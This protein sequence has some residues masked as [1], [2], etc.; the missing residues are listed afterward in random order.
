MIVKSWVN[1]ETIEPFRFNR[2]D[3]GLLDQLYA[4]TFTPEIKKS[5]LFIERCIEYL[6]SVDIHD[7]GKQ[8]QTNQKMTKDVP[9][10]INIYEGYG[11]KKNRTGITAQILPTYCAIYDAAINLGAESYHRS[12]GHFQM[13]LPEKGSDN[14]NFYFHAN[15]RYSL[16]DASTSLTCTVSELP[17]KFPPFFKKF[18]EMTLVKAKEVRDEHKRILRLIDDKLSQN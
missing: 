16:H 10:N 17:D 2:N 7:I 9:Q 5:L 8:W 1:G 3:T 15:Y 18:L 13:D 6:T 4:S 12:L 11:R 14:M